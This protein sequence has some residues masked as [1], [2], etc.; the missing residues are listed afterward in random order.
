[1]EE[2]FVPASGMAMEDV[3]FTEWVK[4]PGEDV[5]PGEV[6][7]LVETDKS[8]VELSSTVPGRLSQHLVE[9]GARVPGGATVAYVLEEGD[10]D[11][12]EPAGAGQNG[13]GM[14][15]NV[16]ASPGAAPP[17][18]P[19]GVAPAPL[20]STPDGR[21]RLSPRQRREMAQAALATPADV[22]PSPVAQDVAPP[23]TTVPD[24]MGVPATES[25]AG[26]EGA[27]AAASSNRQAT[28]ALV[29]QSWREVP[30]FSVGRDV[31]VDGLR[32][33]VAKARAAGAPA[34]V[35]D[36]L[37]LGLS[38]ALEAEGQQPEV[39]LAVA[40][41]WGVLIPVVGPLGG[42]SLADVAR[43]REG[44]VSRA[45]ARRMAS[46]DGATVFATL[47]NLGTSGVTWFTGVVPVG[48][49]AL[50]T[51]GEVNDR[52]AVEE[53]KLVVAP[54]LTAIVTADHRRFDGVDSARLL[55]R[56]AHSLAGAIMGDGP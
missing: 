47:S 54:I 37:L 17:S 40:T 41:Q 1:M 18:S 52:P 23:V 9:V 50:L 10:A 2:I 36:F 39:G 49:V 13:V 20:P 4:Q 8:V 56:F 19:A 46:Q 24:E 34:T 48:Q 27:T 51:V 43:L 11:P 25:S 29:S 53:G 22:D 45:R 12:T 55:E 6:V 7:A 3:L 44:A 35:T 42:A 15:G 38:R 26:P 28:A 16:G 14:A 32:E 5:S 33:A 30:H 31:R 21:H